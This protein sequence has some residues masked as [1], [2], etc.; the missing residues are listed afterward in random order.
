M[1]AHDLV[2]APAPL[3]EFMLAV[4]SEIP[5]NQCGSRVNLLNDWRRL[6]GN[7]SLTTLSEIADRH[8]EDIVR[9]LN[10]RQ[11]AEAILHG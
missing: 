11:R 7:V 2:A 9:L 4:L 1:G 5:M 10:E 3:R 8:R 6:K